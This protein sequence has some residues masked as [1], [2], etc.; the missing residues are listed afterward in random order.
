MFLKS[1]AGK[2]ERICLFFHGLPVCADQR[3]EW[4]KEDESSNW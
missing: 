1:T 2:T 4:R 3:T